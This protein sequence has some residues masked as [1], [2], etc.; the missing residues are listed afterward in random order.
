MDKP[1]IINS[2]NK[3]KIITSPNSPSQ[4]PQ[5]NIQQKIEA[6]ATKDITPVSGSPQ[7]FQMDV[8]LKEK[9]EEDQKKRKKGFLDRIK[10][11]LKI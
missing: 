5:D 2:S 10:G 3:P 8:D 11:I 1:R 4:T 7:P 9:I 6:R